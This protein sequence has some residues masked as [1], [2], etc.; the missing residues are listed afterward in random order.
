[1]VQKNKSKN[2]YREDVSKEIK[3][4]VSL[5]RQPL[6]KRIFFFFYL[7]RNPVIPAV[8]LAMTAGL[9]LAPNRL[10]YCRDR[11]CGFP[12]IENYTPVQYDA[13]PQNWWVIQDKRGVL[14]IA[15]QGVILEYDGSSWRKI[16]IPNTTVRSLALDDN[17]MVY[18]GGVSEVG[19]LIPGSQGTLQYCSLLDK[20]PGDYRNFNDVYRTQ[21]LKNFIYFNPLEYLFRWNTQSQEMECERPR[22]RF[23]FSFPAGNTLYI[24]EDTAGLKRTSSESLSLSLVPGG[25]FFAGKTIYM[26]ESYDANHL[27][28]GTKNSGFFLYDG[29]KAEPFPTEADH[30]V[31]ANNLYRGTRLSSGDFALGTKKG[32]L[33]IIDPQGKLKEIFDKECGLQDN[34]VRYVFEDREK[35]IW[36]ALNEGISKIEYHS[37]V[38]IYDERSGLN[39]L[40]QAVTRHFNVLY[41]G[42]TNGL[43]YL[44]QEQNI[45]GKTPS[46]PVFKTISGVPTDCRFLLS[47]G[48]DLI[49]ATSG[50]VYRVQGKNREGT[51]HHVHSVHQ[52]SGDISNVLQQSGKDKNR[53]WMGTQ[54]GLSSCYRHEGTGRWQEEPCLENIN[55]AVGTIIEDSDGNL[56][57]GT[58]TGRV[59][60]VRFANPGSISDYDVTTY[61][62]KDGLPHGEI[63]VFKAAN[64]VMF[65][66]A[67]GIYRIEKSKNSKRKIFI[68][69]FTFGS[70]FAGASGHPGIYRII[71]DNN[72]DV[73]IHTKK[74]KNFL[75]LAQADGSYD[76]QQAPFGGFAGYQ[77]NAIYPEPKGSVA[78]FGCNQ[79]LVRYDRAL[80][81]DYRMPFTPLIRRVECNGRLIFDGYRSSKDG[82]R[83]IPTIKYNDSKNFSIAF[84]APFYEAQ[85]DKM[86]RYFLEGHDETWS[87]WTKKNKKDYTTLR[88]GSY[89]FRVQARNIHEQPSSEAAFRFRVLPPW[90]TAWWAL[91]F[92]FLFFLSFLFLFARWRSGKL[93]REKKKLEHIIKERTKE[94]AEKN[95]QLEE[96][97]EKLKEMDQV[98]SRFFA[99]ISH[100]F[101]TPLT[102][103]MGPLE[104]MLTEPGR[105]AAEIKKLNLMLRNSQRLLTLINQLLELSK[106]ESGKV[107]LHAEYRDIVPFLKGILDTFGPA[108]DKREIDLTFQFH[109]EKSESGQ[110]IMM[111]FDPNKLEEI[112]FNLLANALKFTPAG[113]QVTVKTGS[114]SPGK[115]VNFPHGFVEISVAD[116]GPGISREQLAHVFDR[117]YQSDTTLEHHRKGSGIGLAIAKELVELHHGR[118]DVHSV[119]GK[120]TEFTIHLPLGKNHLEQGEITGARTPPSNRAVPV[121]IKQDNMEMNPV[122]AQETGEIIAN[123]E[124]GEKTKGWEIEKDVILLVEDSSQL[125]EYMKEALEPGYRVVE[126]ADGE[127]GLQKAR[128]LNPSLIISDIMMPGIDGY[129]LCKEIR[130][131]LDTSHIPLIMLT[132]KASEE[133]II[134]GLETGADDYITKPFN[135]KILLTRIK[136]L[137]ELRNHMQ[138][139]VNREMTLHPVKI[140]ISQLDKK[141]I[142]TLRKTIEENISDP[143][144]NIERLCR[145]LD[146]SQPTLYRKILAFSGESPTEFIRSY[147]LKRG[148]ELL[149]KN[150]GSVLE[151]AFEVGFSSANYFSKCFKKK[152]HQLPSTY[153]AANREQDNP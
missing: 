118:I 31:R 22:S 126:A 127:E 30:Y 145:K 28:I 95:H 74:P 2:L 131:N 92:Y 18:V 109:D 12:F 121:E 15:N 57:L 133:N 125:R 91:L 67:D 81:K 9:L 79:G 75:A 10:L 114:H 139:T 113:G 6:L 135:T 20:I 39:G 85:K 120:G 84:A 128:E 134:Q 60:F 7:T 102:L 146:M 58:F 119:E 152:F 82:N 43:Y 33:V 47:Y 88:P 87:S 68:P 130:N 8:I 13:Q 124:K 3:N 34:N 111:Y 140:P 25:E 77:A 53:I 48:N 14:Y 90:Y 16:S 93:E 94:I 24:D 50:G 35:N 61:D 115:K 64:H 65:A 137:I 83:S 73:W 69:D 150:Y 45:Q 151:V 46:R 32:G 29:N 129:R 112:I 21:G 55:N 104:Q 5:Y 11:S 132:A 66:T 147:R 122:E 27:L 54:K 62:Q 149:K 116:S 148:A 52:V 110:T 72:R 63:H 141:F 117:F 36:L 96:Q 107:K 4:G 97:S 51:T 98:K 144:F 40:V 78:W 101:R 86:F 70:G 100:E 142:K 138:Q 26:L 19:C 42:T 99:N 76:L 108:A 143:D 106:F 41:A 37:P 89:R 1:M 136:N 103:I 59:L 56:W 80:K 105:E 23:L 153:L 49:A 17:G 123:G 71:E 44:E 38:S